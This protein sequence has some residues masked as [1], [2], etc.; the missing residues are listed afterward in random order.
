MARVFRCQIQVV[1]ACTDPRVKLNY[2]ATLGLT[3]PD[4]ANIRNEVLASLTK[5][6]EVHIR[7]DGVR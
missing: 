6:V 7:N 4:L 1:G 3:T 5:D 2:L